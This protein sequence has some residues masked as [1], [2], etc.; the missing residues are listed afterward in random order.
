M[1]E[2]DEEDIDH[3]YTDEIVCP[4][5]GYEVGDSW[6]YGNGDEDIGL[7]ECGR[8]DKEFYTTRN[9]SVCYC[10]EKAIYGTCNG[11]NEEDVVIEDYHSTLGR[12]NGLCEKCGEEAK[13]YMRR[14]YVKRIVR[15]NDYYVK[16]EV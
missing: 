2:I 15:N 9:I 4:F 8:C 11:C 13:A 1:F 6:E 12:Y 16:G 10:T 5:C 7:I 14:E 3:E